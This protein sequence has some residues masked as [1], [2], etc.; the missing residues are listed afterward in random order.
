VPVFQITDPETGV[1]IVNDASYS[2]PLL[3]PVAIDRSNGNLYVTFEDKQFSGG[4]Y[5]SIAF[6]MSTDG[7]LTWS[8]PIQVNQTPTGI[9]PVDRNAFLP[10]V[11]VA[12]DGTIGV[13]YYDLR[14]ND[15]NP[16]L[17]TDYWM[18]Q[19]HPSVGKSPTDPT[20]WGSELRLTDSSF[21]LETA[22]RPDGVYFLGDYEGL[23][24]VGTDFL[25]AW[26]MPHD[27]DID[28]VYFRRVFN[29]GLSNNGPSIVTSA[30]PAPAGLGLIASTLPGNQSVGGVAGAGGNGYGGSWD[31]GLLIAPQNA[32]TP[33]ALTVTGSTIAANKATR[34]AAGGSS[35]GQGIGG[36][37]YFASGGVVCLDL[38]TSM[39]IFGNTASTS[40]NDVFGLFTTC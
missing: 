29:G 9:P 28:S 5:S 19:Y 34:C 15:P 31:D 12:S 10:S 38:F 22:L 6:T 26:A 11:A 39:N 40:N 17:P 32:G 13:T 8:A 23:T 33:A 24:T 21:N 30:N 16:R 7:G 36:G 14:F 20:A 37:L 2:P 27:S 3:S 35:A 1:S 4:Q 25:A 18:V